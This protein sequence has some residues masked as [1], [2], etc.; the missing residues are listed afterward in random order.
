MKKFNKTNFIEAFKKNRFQVTQTCEDLKIN[1]GT[2]YHHLKKDKE[3]FKEIMSL[4]SS[5]EV[6][7]QKKREYKSFDEVKFLE[8]FRENLSISKTCKKLKIE[9]YSYYN[10]IKCNPYFKEIVK[11]TKNEIKESILSD[12]IIE[13]KEGMEKPNTSIYTKIKISDAL[14]RLTKEFTANKE[15]NISNKEKDSVPNFQNQDSNLEEVN[16][17]INDPYKFQLRRKLTDVLSKLESLMI[18]RDKIMRL[19]KSYNVTDEQLLPFHNEALEFMEDM[20]GYSEILDNAISSDEDIDENIDYFF[21]IMDEVIKSGY[22]KLSKV[23]FNIGDFIDSETVSKSSSLVLVDEFTEELRK[24]NIYQ[25]G[26]DIQG[27]YEMLR[28]VDEERRKKGKV[29]EDE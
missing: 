3:F 10:H 8:C 24:T 6:K 20:K 5:L 12:L 13:I 4:R 14:I 15:K 9:P 18:E 25:I 28:L 17:K 7:P 23:A 2:F 27:I 29:D 26:A 22:K 11:D 1:R 21:D 16:F 19:A